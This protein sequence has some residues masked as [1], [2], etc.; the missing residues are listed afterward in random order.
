MLATFQRLFVW[1]YSLDRPDGPS[2][3]LTHLRK[4]CCELSVS[5]DEL[6]ERGTSGVVPVLLLV[7]IVTRHLH[8]RAT[9]RPFCSH[10][11]YLPVIQTQAEFKGRD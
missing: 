7:A 5:R 8:R 1:N 2:L 3:S 9:A 6:K 4:F 11:Q 10:H